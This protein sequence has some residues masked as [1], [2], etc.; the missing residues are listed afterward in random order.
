MEKVPKAKLNTFKSGHKFLE[1]EILKAPDDIEFRFL[2][3]VVQESAP[4][5]LNYNQNKQEDKLLIINKY[6][7]LDAYLQNYILQYCKQSKVL[8]V[9]DLKKT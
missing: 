2:R 1:A 4:K 8:T 5:I 3:L 9:K 6:K 7:S